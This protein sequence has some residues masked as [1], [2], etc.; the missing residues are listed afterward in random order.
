MI[1]SITAL[2]GSLLAA[3]AMAQT[4]APAPAPAEP[5]PAASDDKTKS[6]IE[7][8]VSGLK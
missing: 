6:V 5:T 3:A 1:K 2:L 7:K 4:A 8:G